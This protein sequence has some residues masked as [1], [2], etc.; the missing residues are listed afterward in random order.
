MKICI[1]I[2]TDGRNDYLART[3]ESM[4]K[5]L[6]FP[7]GSE[8]FKI[9]VDDWPEDRDL[10]ELKKLSKKYKIDKLVLNDSNIGI[11]KTVQKAWSLVP[12][13]ID[14]IWHQENDFEYLDLVNISKMMKVLESPII[15]QTALVRQPWFPDEKEAGSLMNTRPSRFKQASVAGED[16]IIHR[17]HFTHN[18]SLYKRKWIAQ[19]DNYNEYNFKDY[20]LKNNSV[21]YFAYMGKIENPH[22][23]VHIGEKKR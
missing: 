19:M 12:E 14:Y 9:M 11:D 10:K 22:A 3:L 5:H 2:L 23:I 1:I 20:I 6:V 17:D 8:V 4:E 18:P 16:I 15:V 13:D 21:V 7:E